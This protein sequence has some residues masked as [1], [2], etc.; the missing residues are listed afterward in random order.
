LKFSDCLDTATKIFNKYF[1]VSGRYLT[2]AENKTMVKKLVAVSID[3]SGN[4]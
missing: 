2:A 4:F 3:F 1:I